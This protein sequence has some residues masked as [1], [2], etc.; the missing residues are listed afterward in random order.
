MCTVCTVNWYAHAGMKIKIDTNM[1]NSYKRYA[2]VTKRMLCKE[3]IL[4]N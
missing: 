3:G 1:T 4:V 2:I